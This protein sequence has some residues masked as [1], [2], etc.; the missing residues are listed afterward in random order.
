M[1]NFFYLTSLH[2][3]Y[4]DNYFSSRAQFDVTVGR[5][6]AE[7]GNFELFADKFPQH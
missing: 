3:S 5:V 2:I 4:P 6:Q 1:E 7:G